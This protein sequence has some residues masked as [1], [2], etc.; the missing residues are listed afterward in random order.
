MHEPTVGALFLTRKI[1]VEDKNIKYDI[2]DTA[3]QERYHSLTPMYYKNAKA[4]IVVF[5]VSSV[6]SFERAQK[7]TI[8]LQEKADK[9]IVIALCGNKCD[10]EE[11]KVTKEVRLNI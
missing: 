1:K 7:W 10:L 2:W 3:G 9:G 5:D 4:A 8:E 11:R 6:P